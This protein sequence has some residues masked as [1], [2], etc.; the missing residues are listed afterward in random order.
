MKTPCPIYYIILFIGVIAACKKP[1]TPPA[2]TTNY[3][4]LVVDGVINA[5]AN[6]VTT[7]LLSRTR[8]LSAGNATNTESGAQVSIESQAG[9]SFALVSQGSGVYK[10]ASLTL[11]T[12]AQYR[13]RIIANGNTYLSAFVPVKQ[14]PPIDSIT[15]KQAT[16]T[17][18]ALTIFAHTHDP[19][20]NTRFY[21]W[22][23]VETWQ[24]HAPLDAELEL[25]NNG[26]I[27]YND[28]TTQIYNC[29]GTVISPNISV[30]TSVNLSQ[31]VISYAPVNI[32]LQNDKRLTVRY[33]INVKQYG[34]TKEAYAYWQILAN[35]TQQTGSIF[36][37][38]PSQIVGNIQCV[39]DQS[40]PVI[41]FASASYITEKRIFID[42][43]QLVDW[44]ISSIPDITCTLGADPQDPNDF[45]IFHNIDSTYGPYYF[46]GSNVI[47]AKKDCLDCR[48][49]GGT[50]IKPDFWQ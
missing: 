36:D 48:R 7:I 33:S 17:T 38:Q 46:S 13:L 43:R 31:D 5:G 15:W 39:S 29:W 41:G 19:S 45:R 27:F 4:Y 1:F 40:Q 47:I 10:S 20:N 9:G 26:L 28:P 21:R 49:Q 16:D 2:I 22:D 50:S 6:S 42:H 25:D 18:K 44:A 32:I 24:Y 8:Q 35:S 34:L 14:T 37:V 3:N 12:A 11:D 23:Y 30:A